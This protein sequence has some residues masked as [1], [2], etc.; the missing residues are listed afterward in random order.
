MPK[1]V[2]ISTKESNAPFSNS[3]FILISGCFKVKSLGLTV[4]I[5][6]KV[7]KFALALLLLTSMSL[8]PTAIASASNTPPYHVVTLAEND[9]GTDPVFTLQSANAP[10]ALTSFSNLSPSF[11]NIGLTFKSWNT[12]QD[13]SGVTYSDGA[14][15]DFTASIVLYA[16]WKAPYHVVTFIEN[17]S[18]SDPV[19]SLQTA[20]ASSPLTAISNLL[21]ALNN[22]GYKFGNWNTAQ[23]GSGLNYADSAQYG[24]STDLTLYAQWV[25]LPTTSV[26]LSNGN[27]TS[28]PESGPVGTSITLPTL[29]DSLNPG[30]TFKGWNTIQNGSG[31]EYA[32]GT[33]YV[34]SA[35]GTLY[36]QW[37]PNVYSVTFAFDG[38]MTTQT[39]LSFTVGTS[40]VVLPASVLVGHS[41]VGWFT[42]ATAGTLVGLPG[43]SF[44]PTGSTTV[45]AQ[46]ALDTGSVLTFDANGG[47]G[48]LANVTGS[49]AS[50]VT[51]PPITGVT[52]LGSVFAGWNTLANGSGTS[53]ASGASFVLSVDQTLYA[54]WTKI[55]IDTVTIDANGGSGSSAALTGTPGALVTIPGQ[56]VFLRAGYTLTRWNTSPSGSGT[57]YAIG[58]PL[59]LTGSMTLYAQWTVH[60]SSVLFGAIG[61]FKKNSASLSTALKNQIQRLALTVRSRKYL[62]VNLYGYTETTG[63][64]S[65]NISLSRARALNVATY[66][67]SRLRALRVK[68]VTVRAAGEGAISG[69]SGSAYSRVEVF[70]E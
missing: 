69:R 25:V 3:N 60:K 45:Y 20:D 5:E 62:T 56:T 15:Y 27:G 51:I 63:L 4:N 61:M 59:T 38:G 34:F 21:P 40:P 67:R 1:R 57:S 22:V 33:Q 8:G 12:A 6:S 55:A 16:I 7:G 9:N 43:A 70:G 28:T 48:Q 11:S 65:F 36:A 14:L 44:T 39:T 66:L 58:Q 42:S 30:Y 35:N 23:D 52:N 26:V 47:T 37:L 17:S 18:G 64:A 68:G 13:G 53:Y 31:I 32:G 10:V 24:F 29:I 46:W 54:Q 41:L 2:P 19:F 50:T 49:P